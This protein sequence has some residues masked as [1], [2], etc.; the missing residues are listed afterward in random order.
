MRPATT[1]ADVCQANGHPGSRK[2][3]DVVGAVGQ[4]QGHGAV[5]EVESMSEIGHRASNLRVRAGNRHRRPSIGWCAATSGRRLAAGDGRVQLAGHGPC[6]CLHG[7][8]VVGDPVLVAGRLGQHRHEDGR[9]RRGVEIGVATDPSPADRHDDG[10]IASLTALS[11]EVLMSRNRWSPSSAARSITASS[12]PW[13][14]QNDR[15]LDATCSQVAYA[16]LPDQ[17]PSRRSGSA[18]HDPRPPVR[19]PGRASADSASGK[20]W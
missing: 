19:R 10:P 18:A 17:S 14:D 20:Y 5:F 2:N 7:G 15:K 1:I 9:G 3:S 8:S 11:I 12:D 16:S 13:S 6:E 4:G